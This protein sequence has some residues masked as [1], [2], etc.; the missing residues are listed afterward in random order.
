M[1]FCLLNKLRFT[2]ATQQVLFNSQLQEPLQGASRGKKRFC[3]HA[4]TAR[5]I[6]RLAA[7]SQLSLPH[8]GVFDDD[9]M[10]MMVM[11]CQCKAIQFKGLNATQIADHR[12]IRLHANP[13]E[14][15]VNDD[16]DDNDDGD[17][18]DGVAMSDGPRRSLWSRIC[19][20]TLAPICAMP[21][22]QKST[23]AS[24]T[25]LRDIIMM[26]MMAMLMIIVREG[27]CD[28]RRVLKNR[29]L[30]ATSQV[31]TSPR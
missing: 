27:P 12:Q 23:G 15:Q 2:D 8:E 9:Q 11:K 4:A 22:R 16:D 28:P 5:Q 17:G 29:L 24:T 31:P 21:S 14:D 10:V 26:M 20:I 19:Q 3:G 25:E 18:D 1:C 7:T 13:D 30:K 6:E